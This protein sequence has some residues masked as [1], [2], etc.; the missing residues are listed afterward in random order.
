MA[1][2]KGNP[3]LGKKYIPRGDRVA[4]TIGD[5]EFTWR[6]L[7]GMDIFNPRAPKILE[8]ALESLGIDTWGKFLRMSPQDISLYAAGDDTGFVAMQLYAHVTHKDPVMWVA[9]GEKAVRWTT[10]KRRLKKRKRQ[11]R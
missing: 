8:D 1:R 2:K 6:E 3:I 5:R 10:Y 11:Q 7:G 9:R 4:L